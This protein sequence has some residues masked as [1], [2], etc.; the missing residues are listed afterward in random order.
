V[1]PENYKLLGEKIKKLDGK[2]ELVDSAVIQEGEL[3]L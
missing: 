1:E 3:K 2:I